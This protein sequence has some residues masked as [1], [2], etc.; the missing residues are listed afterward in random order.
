MMTEESTVSY[1][2]RSAEVDIT[3]T[4][5]EEMVHN[6]FTIGTEITDLLGIYHHPAR[7]ATTKTIKMRDRDILATDNA[8]LTSV[9]GMST[10][11][12]KMTDPRRGALAV[13]RVH[14]SGDVEG[15]AHSLP[16]M[17]IVE[18]V[19]LAPIAYIFCANALRNSDASLEGAARTVDASPWRILFSV[20]LP[21]L[22]PPIVYSAVLIFTMAIETLLHDDHR[23]SQRPPHRRATRRY[24]RVLDLLVQERDPVHQPGLRHSRA[25][26]QW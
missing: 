21:M 2:R 18:A 25:Q 8:L 24:H 12:T 17:A 9:S 4:L 16:G 13:H 11:V 19:A 14:L 6:D 3:E 7:S 23:D 1:S 26:R 10:T 22:R 5:S 20:V 15:L